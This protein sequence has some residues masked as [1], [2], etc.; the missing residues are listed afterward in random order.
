MPPTLSINPQTIAP[1]PVIDEAVV[2]ITTL[3]ATLEGN[4]VI[5]A[6]ADRIAVF[7]QADG[8]CRHNPR[9]HYLAHFLRQYGLAT[10]LVDLLTLEEQMVCSRAE[11]LHYD[12]DTLAMRLV[13][14]TDWLQSQP[15]TDH[16]Q[17]SYLG[18]QRGAQVGFLA[19]IARPTA[20]EAIVIPGNNLQ[21]SHLAL[22][23]VTTPTLLIVS[24]LEQEMLERNRQIL[25]QL[26]QGSD[27]AIVPR[28]TNLLRESSSLE[29]I[30]RFTSQW[31][32]KL[33]G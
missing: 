16:L 25:H 33:S 8:S 22:P 20:V 26:P 15:Y 7:V 5:P 31:L 14:V 11:A 18:L 17:I 30:G 6:N 32:N 21:N 29:Y 10:L 13:A 12:L 23:F 24:G 9:N 1:K 27:L 4:L 19:A 2:Q 28:A 3:G